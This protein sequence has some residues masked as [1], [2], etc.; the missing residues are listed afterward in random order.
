LQLDQFTTH[1]GLW[2]RE[3]PRVCQLLTYSTLYLET[4]G[5]A[6]LFV[7]F[8]PGL[9]RLIVISA[10]LLF[11]AGLAVSMELSNFPFVCMVGWLALVPTSFWDRLGAQL[12]TP[13]RQGLTLLY[14]PLTAGAR[15]LVGWLQT[16]LALPDSQLVEASEAGGQRARVRTQ[17]G[18]GVLDHQGQESY[19]REAL[20]QLVSLSPLFGPL[21]GLLRRWPLGPVAGWVLHRLCGGPA[22]GRVRPA[23]TP[24]WTPPGGSIVQAVLGFL[25]L[26]CVLWN[27]NTIDVDRN[28][29]LFPPQ[30]TTL[31]SAL[32]IE[33]GWGLFAPAP[34]KLYGWFYVVGKRKDG[35]EVNVLSGG[36]PDTSKPAYLSAWF[37]NGRWRKLMM[38]LPDDV[39]YP[40]LPDNYA[41][42]LFAEWN[43]HHEGTEQLS[44]LEVYWMKEE[45][46]PPGTEKP[47]PVKVRLFPPSPGAGKP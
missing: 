38:N 20:V 8:A 9:M 16:F 39:Q 14:D 23:T 44:S 30:L 1:F 24:A 6:L 5:P 26:Y 25:I 4:L 42:F 11:H 37:P 10:F 22:S 43:R 33:Q 19:R 46:V 18:W 29:Y 35:Q 15:R 34:G 21:A 32:S 12:R 28:R 2:L 17:G 36:P 41:R 7:P 45:A 47:A 31:G 13:E 40:T 3:F 27:V